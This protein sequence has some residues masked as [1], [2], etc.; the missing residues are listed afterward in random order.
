MKHMIIKSVFLIS[1]LLFIPV[2]L[3]W[4]HPHVFIA[5]NLK[6]VFDEKGMAGFN[7]YWKFDEM[8]SSMI[9]DDHDLNR[10]GI[11]EK[12]EV[13]SIK[14][15]AFSYIAE[16]N[17]F[18]YVKIDNTPFEVKY[19]TDFF[20]RIDKGNLIY[21]FFIPCHISAAKNFKHISIASYDP[22]YYSAVYFTERHPFAIENNDRFEV[23]AQIKIDKSTL[24]Y[25]DMVNPWALFLD[26]KLK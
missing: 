26:F 9:C 17:Y 21:E 3:T 24:I 14:G 5:Q 10:N 23:K 19:V 16:F 20:A 18:I 22:N 7:V 6:I 8:F 13:A 15:K 1:C 25:Y 4:A 12:T 11:L 2:K